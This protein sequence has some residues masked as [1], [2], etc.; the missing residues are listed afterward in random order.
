MHRIV[1]AAIVYIV[2][3]NGNENSTLL[4]SAMG[5]VGGVNTVLAHTLLVNSLNY[6]PLAR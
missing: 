4:K 1:V 2:Y 6:E 5:G 3:F